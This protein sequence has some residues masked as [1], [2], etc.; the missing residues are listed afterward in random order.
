MTPNPR[1]LTRAALVREIARRGLSSL[2]PTQLRRA[3]LG[4]L[5][6]L[7]IRADIRAATPS[8]VLDQKEAG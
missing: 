2:S 1:D 6:R 3:K 8:D 4:K 5:R 7:I